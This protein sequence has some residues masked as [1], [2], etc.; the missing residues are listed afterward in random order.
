MINSCTQYLFIIC[1][2]GL[3]SCR[4]SYDINSP[5]GVH[6]NFKLLNNEKFDAEIL[7]IDSNYIYVLNEGVLSKLS[8]TEVNKIYAFELENNNR[9]IA[10]AFAM[11]S[12]GAIGIATLS[13]DDNKE[14]SGISLAL[15]VGAG[16][17]LLA[18][19]PKYKFNPPLS[20][21]QIHRLRLYS[22]YPQGLSK[23][24]IIYLEEYYKK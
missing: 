16:V 23:D 10:L 22:R 14:I 17:A 24:Q 12:A 9:E 6:S 11:V 21:E 2:L 18:K 5:L 15:S 20:K 3:A 19:V 13:D 8:F 7:L 4:S 1:L